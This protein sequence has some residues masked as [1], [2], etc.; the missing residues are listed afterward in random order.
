MNAIAYKTKD[1]LYCIAPA[2]SFS[3]RHYSLDIPYCSIRR[4]IYTRS[5]LCFADADPHEV[6]EVLTREYRRNGERHQGFPVFE[7]V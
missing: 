2:P 4:A 1:G 3:S 6:C 7:E 5:S